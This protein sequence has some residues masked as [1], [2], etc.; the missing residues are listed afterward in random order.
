MQGH[1]EFLF[2]VLLLVVY[3]PFLSKCDGCLC[4]SEAVFSVLIYGTTLVFFIIY[5]FVLTAVCVG[6]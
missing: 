5:Y 6:N 3:V 4:Y 1:L 2:S